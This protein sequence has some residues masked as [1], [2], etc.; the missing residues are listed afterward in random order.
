LGLVTGI[1]AIDKREFTQGLFWL[2]AFRKVRQGIAILNVC[3]GHLA[4]D[5]Q[6]KGIECDVMLAA[7]DLLARVTAFGAACLGGFDRLTVDDGDGRRC[8]FSFCPTNGDDQGRRS[9][10]TDRCKS[11]RRKAVVDY[12]G[13]L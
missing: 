11:A 2:N 3:R 6:A 5:R 8:V 13:Y 9:V 10:P 7:L 4:L 1:S 12:D